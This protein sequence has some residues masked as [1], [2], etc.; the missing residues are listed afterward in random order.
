MRIA[1]A[2]YPIDFLADWAEYAAKITDWVAKAEADLLVF[3]EYGAME[4]AALGG[5][6]VAR[7]LEASLLHVA[8]LRPQMD[9][10]FAGLAARHA[11]HILAPSGPV[12]AGGKRLNRATLFGPQG[13]IGDQ[14]K[15]IMTR[16]E[17]EIWHVEA[18]QGLT[19]F[20][21]DLGKIGVVICYDSEFPLL[22]RA[23]AEAGAEILLVPS[24]TD[25]M[26]GYCRVKIGA[27]ARALEN[28]CVVVHSCTV[29]AAHWCAAVDQNIGAAA[30]YGP[31]DRGW[32][33]TGV[34]EQG[35]LN[36]AGWVRAD[37]DLAMVAQSRASGAVL[38]FKHWGEQAGQAKNITF[39]A[40]NRP[41]Y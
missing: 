4:L 21:T 28:Q 26:D 38:P 34:L 19:F 31:P 8:A 25:A 24:C 40:P 23:L 16:F 35:P 11:C 33:E 12:I 13:R 7:D 18:G 1:S 29:G 32:P 15:A 37:V 36:V 17:R 27:M 41:K 5:A 22:S 20:D 30:I 6:D 2:A 14:D 10:L 9:A 39:T 3:P